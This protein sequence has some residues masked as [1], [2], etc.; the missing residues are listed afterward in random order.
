M[1][2]SKELAAFNIDAILASIVNHQ[3]TEAVLMQ[4]FVEHERGL[5]AFKSRY[6]RVHGKKVF[7][8]INKDIFWYS[9]HV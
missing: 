7:K 3:S 2:L 6:K 8:K 4:P 1:A 5:K 9:R